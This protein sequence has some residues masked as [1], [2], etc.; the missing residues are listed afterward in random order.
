MG[1]PK[2][3]RIKLLLETVICKIGESGL[4]IVGITC[5]QGS[6]NRKAFLF[7]ELPGRD[8][9]QCLVHKKYFAFMTSLILRQYYNQRRRKN[10]FVPYFTKIVFNG[11]WNSKHV[12]PDVFEKQKIKLAT[13][14][15]SANVTSAIYAA[16]SLNCFS[17]KLIFLFYYNIKYQN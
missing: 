4:K 2:G 7:S 3:H 12:Y 14:V 10:N 8:L 6:A 5:D 9:G 17:G 13:Q 1:S 15:F 11:A 16:V